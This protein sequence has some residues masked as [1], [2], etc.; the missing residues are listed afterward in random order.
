SVRPPPAHTPLRPDA[1]DALARAALVQGE[2][3]RP[4][5]RPARLDRETGHA[6]RGR[7]ALTLH[8]LVDPLRQAAG[9]GRVVLRGV[10]DAEAAA[11]VEVRQ[12]DAARVKDLRLKFQ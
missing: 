6:Q 8:D 3:G 1:V 10:R 4:D 11:Q 12:L 5:D 9:R 2:D 7:V